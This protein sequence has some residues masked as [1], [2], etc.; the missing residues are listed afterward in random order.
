[1]FQLIKHQ[2]AKSEGKNGA[3]PLDK[4]VNVAELPTKNGAEDDS[5]VGKV[6]WCKLTLG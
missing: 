3:R 4:F 5:K 2:P 1:M 6:G